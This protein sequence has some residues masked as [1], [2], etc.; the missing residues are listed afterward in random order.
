L[1]I[2]VFALLIIL[3]SFSAA[4]V[5]EYRAC[6]PSPSRASVMLVDPEII[7]IAAGEFKGILADYLLLKAS[8]FLGG[9]YESAEND[10]IAVYHL[11]KQSLALDPYFFQTCY[12]IQANLPWEA[13]MPEKAA[14]LLEISREYRYWDWQPGFYAGFDYYHFLND[15]L[16]ASK[17][18]METATRPNAPALLGLLGARL[19][20]KGGKT[21]AGI[22]FLQEMYKNTDDKETRRQINVRMDALKGLLVI[23]KAIGKF[24]SKFDHSPQSLDELVE[25]GI[26]SKLP[27]NPYKKYFDYKDGIIGF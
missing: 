23:E 6:A 25:T 9:R 10:W 21:E 20:Q 1:H 16:T 13:K 2:A 11:F 15:N 22:I 27:K 24:I 17:I 14:E 4:R 12:Y 7:K 19:A 18:L 8:V 26:L 3:Y 5:K